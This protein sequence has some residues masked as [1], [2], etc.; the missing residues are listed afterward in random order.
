MF[1]ILSKVLWFLT[2]PGNLVLILLT[3]GTVLLWT[4][5]R[6]G[7]RRLVL[8]STLAFILLAVFPVGA[9][10]LQTL[11]N[12]IPA[13]T[14]LPERVGGVIVLG[15]MV[16]QFVSRAR[17]QAS[18]GG[19]V[20]R[21]TE[22][23]ALARRYPDAKLIFTGGSGNL[24]N[25]QDKEADYVE[26][27]LHSLGMDTANVVFESESRNTYENAVLSKRL[28]SIAPDE[29]WILVTSA[30]HMPRALGVFRQ[31]GWPVI[32]YPVDYGTTGTME[33]EPTFN[34]LGGVGNGSV[35]LHEWLGLT[36]YYLT[37]RTN[38]LYPAIDSN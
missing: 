38:T 32:P 28:V 36:F 25:Q 31:A 14:Q 19:A 2:D 26:P 7:G 22:F 29:P 13:P 34:L 30:F 8:L 37:G 21:L 6:R 11:E 5:W 9:I 3:I 24:L 15:G 4:P 17:G 23:A 35:A 16:D 12:R 20:E 1:F 10:M 33:L 27:F 18:M